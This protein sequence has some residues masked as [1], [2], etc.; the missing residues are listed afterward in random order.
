MASLTFKEY[1]KDN[2]VQN[3]II[4]KLEQYCWYSIFK[5]LSKNYISDIHSNC[6]T[7]C[8]D[9]YIH[10]GGI[11]QILQILQNCEKSE[12]LPV[13]RTRKTFE[14]QVGDV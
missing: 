6:S 14:H 7:D 2:L 9:R 4:Y 5:I 12:I 1:F 10:I 11:Q 13:Q 8:L 3:V